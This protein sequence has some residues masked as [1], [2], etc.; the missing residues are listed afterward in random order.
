MDTELLK[1]AYGIHRKL[2]IF[3][4][5][6]KDLKETQ[7]I[8]VLVERRNPYNLSKALYVRLDQKLR[9]TIISFYEEGIAELE[10]ELEQL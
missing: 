3:K 4:D 9:D 5:T 1:K 10:K 8:N 6:L 2:E 7:T